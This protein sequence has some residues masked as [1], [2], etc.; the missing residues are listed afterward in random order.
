MKRTKRPTVSYDPTQSS[1]ELDDALKKGASPVVLN[2]QP[3]PVPYY[4]QPT[5]SPV[6]H[7]PISESWLSKIHFLMDLFH[8]R[9]DMYAGSWISS[10]AGKPSIF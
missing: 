4:P 3:P 1:L 7:P 5:R 10:P 9:R 2:H 8:V 6:S